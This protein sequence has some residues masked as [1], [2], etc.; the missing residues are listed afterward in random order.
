MEVILRKKTKEKILGALSILY[1][2]HTAI[3]DC[4]QKEKYESVYLLLSDCRDVT[5]VIINTI[6]ESEGVEFITI[7][8]FEEYLNMINQIEQGFLTTFSLKNIRKALDKKLSQAKNSVKNDVK[9]KLEIVFM[10]Y[11][12]SM[13]DSLESVWN[14]A[15]D[16]QD[17]E[18]YVVPIPYYDRNPDFSFGTYHYEGNDFPDYVSVLHYES[19][20]V[21]ERQP[22]IIYIHNP[23]DE[24]N[25]VTSVDGRFYSSEL[26][27]Y[28]KHLVYI[29]Y[30]VVANK[31]SE[32]NMINMSI[33]MNADKI[34]LQSNRV[35]E[36]SINN[37]S[38][39]IGKPLGS[40]E[41]KIVALGSPKIDSI[42]NAK[43][44]DFELPKGWKEIINGKKVILY[45]TSIGTALKENER[46]L[47][48]IKM[49]ID[50]FK[51]REDM[52]LWWRPHPLLK[53]TFLS[54][55]EEY[56]EEY[57]KIVQEY[58]QGG[59][60]IYDETPDF[61]RAIVYSDIYYGD[62]KSSMVT[63]YSVTGKLVVFA[64]IEEN[65][66]LTTFEEDSRLFFRDNSSFDVL[67]RNENPDGTS[68]EKI[69]LYIKNEVLG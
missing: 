18:V 41:E 5:N 17:C 59:Y 4:I 55:R 45:N 61:R 68:G 21:K 43:K 48:K 11:K 33:C 26:K 1:K 49:T 12:A 30:F 36:S 69:H 65:E 54:L 3:A 31:N 24:F 34:I 47:E 63:L 20:D 2:T 32:V 7:S 40:L 38:K 10:P 67:L 25:T 16:D 19:Y 8:Y 22:D 6:K 56:A 51:K 35:R 9:E 62:K 46:F 15:R 27:K 57:L 58:K 28:T 37:L 50:F 66:K 42:V 64:N 44:K 39:I 13:W 52:V 29:P 14:A 60:G 23:Y 53:A